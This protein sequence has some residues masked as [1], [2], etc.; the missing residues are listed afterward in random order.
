VW[1]QRQQR[2]LPLRLLRQPRQQHGLLRLLV[3]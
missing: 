1:Q 2:Q 3:V